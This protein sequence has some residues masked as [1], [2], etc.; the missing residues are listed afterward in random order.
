[1]ER[2]LSTTSKTIACEKLV[3]AHAESSSNG[4]ARR[5]ID[6]TQ[7]AAELK[8]LHRREVRKI[9]T[10]GFRSDRP[11]IAAAIPEKPAIAIESSIRLGR[12]S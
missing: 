11:W 4:D 10:W 5:T 6:R 2:T 9:R 12:I 7:I 3:A 1:M 8:V